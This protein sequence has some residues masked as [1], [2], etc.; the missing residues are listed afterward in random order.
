MPPTMPAASNTNSHD[1]RSGAAPPTRDESR[2]PAHDTTT[3][4]ARLTKKY[5]RPRSQREPL[6]KTLFTSERT[7]L[8]RVVGGLDPGG[9]SHGRSDTPVTTAKTTPRTPGTSSALCQP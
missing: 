8:A 9:G 6:V 4:R 1:T 5:E 2:L 7:M 3:V